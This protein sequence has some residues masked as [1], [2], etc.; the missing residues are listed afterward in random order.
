[1]SVRSDGPPPSASRTLMRPALAGALAFIEG[2]QD[3]TLDAR[4]LTAWLTTYLVKPGTITMPGTV[5]E[6]GVAVVSLREMPTGAW[7]PAFEDRLRTIVGAARVRISVSLQGLLATPP[8]DRFLTTAIF[9]GRV[10]R[11]AGWRPKLKGTERLSDMVLA[12]LAAD[13]LAHREEYDASL[14]VCAICGRV[15]LRRHAPV[16][17]RCEQH[18]SARSGTP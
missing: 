9:A 14:C 5:Q 10:D 16:R 6:P 2:A 7:A 8:D 12:I 3:R 15:S 4:G 13:I 18:L 11:L 1:M 17:T